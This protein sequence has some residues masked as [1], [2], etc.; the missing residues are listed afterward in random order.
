MGTDAG[1]RVDLVMRGCGSSILIGDGRQGHPMSKR[2]KAG[3]I[4]NGVDSVMLEHFAGRNTAGMPA[5]L[6]RYLR[7]MVINVRR[8]VSGIV[9]SPSAASRCSSAGTELAE[10]LL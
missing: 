3:E 8:P 10:G 6:G 1:R 7:L 9:C 5:L 4:R 2:R